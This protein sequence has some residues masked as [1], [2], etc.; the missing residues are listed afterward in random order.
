MYFKN[1]N[2]KRDLVINFNIRRAKKDFQSFKTFPSTKFLSQ[3]YLNFPVFFK[4]LPYLKGRDLCEKK[5]V[6]KKKVQNL[7]VQI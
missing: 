2:R 1:I 5:L 6:Q 4:R 3:K 7:F